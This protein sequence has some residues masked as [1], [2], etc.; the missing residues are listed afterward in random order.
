MQT[1]NT[2]QSNNQLPSTTN[3]DLNQLNEVK[4]K[5]L[6]VAHCNEKIFLSIENN[7]VN[8]IMEHY[9]ESALAFQVFE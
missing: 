4:K 5:F 3:I 6:M 7:I 8:H 2:Q 9:E 1:L